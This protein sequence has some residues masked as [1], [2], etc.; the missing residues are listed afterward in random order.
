MAR[1]RGLVRAVRM[2]G[3][4][5]QRQCAHR[6]RIVHRPARDAGHH[7][8]RRHAGPAH[9]PDPAGRAARRRWQP[10]ALSPDRGA[11][12]LARHPTAAQPGVP[13]PAAGGHPRT[14]AV[15]VRALCRMALRR[16]RG[17]PHGG[18]R[19]AH[20]HRPVPRDRLPLRYAPAGRGGSG[21]HHRRGRAGAQRPR[22]ADLCRQPP[23]GRGHGI[24][25][26]GRHPL[27]P[28]A[29]PGRTRRHPG[30]DLP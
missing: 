4:G 25:C 15:A 26:R 5:R 7:A 23:A 12:V 19:H 27:P 22:A 21:L 9:R 8:G 6:A 10:G 2:A 17:R 16:W 30:V 11:V 1:P 3:G 14:D 28:R 29:Q 18:V 13:E 24:R 20:A